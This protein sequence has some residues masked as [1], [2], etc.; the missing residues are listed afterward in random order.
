MGKRPYIVDPQFAPALL[1]VAEYLELPSLAKKCVSSLG[2]SLEYVSTWGD[3]PE[4]V[5]LSV[6]SATEY[7][8]CEEQIFQSCGLL[9]CF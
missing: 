8:L 9:Y 5:I 2:K 4:P 1:M 3:L 6:I 7:V